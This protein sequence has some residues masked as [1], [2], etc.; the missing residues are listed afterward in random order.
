MYSVVLSRF[1]P[2]QMLISGINQANIYISKYPPAHLSQDIWTSY[3]STWPNPS[4]EGKTKTHHLPPLPRLQNKW[5]INYVDCISSKTSS[6]SFIT[7][8]HNV[9]LQ[10]GHS[11]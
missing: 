6:M 5:K 3:R 8:P 9:T 1:S 7:Q 4:L 10:P 11:R 2:K